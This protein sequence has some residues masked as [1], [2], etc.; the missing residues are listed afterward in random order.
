MRIPI[1]IGSKQYNIKPISELTTK[2]F[3]EL[4]NI[5]GL[6]TVKYIAWQTST[7]LS[8]AF[9]AVTSKSV[10][11][12]IGK[13]P[14][15]TKLPRPKGFDYSKIIDTVGQRHQIENSGKTGFPLLVFSLAV[16]QAR[17]NNADMVAELETL[18][19]SRP[20]TEILPAGFFFFRN[21]R[22]GKRNVL[23][24]LSLLRYLTNMLR[25]RRPQAWSV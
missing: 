18:Y 24:P 12:A 25:I 17:S 21:Y 1:K 20:F 9:F 23:N 15:I 22:H 6:D 19:L 11:R 3:I 4:S 16:S 10:E 8:K 5:E 13:V 14:D 7:D 2:E